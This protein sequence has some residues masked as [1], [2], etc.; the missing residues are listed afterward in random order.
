GILF[1]RQGNPDRAEAE[2]RTALS[3]APNFAPAAVNLADL[4]RGL[5]RDSAGEAV[6]RSALQRSLDD[7]SLLYALGLLIVRN[8]HH[9]EALKLFD[10]AAHG[11]PANAR[12]AYVYAVALND[13]GQ[14]AA[15][16]DVL[17]ANVNTHPFDQD[18]L[19]ALA[20]FLEQQDDFPKAL[21]YAQRFNAL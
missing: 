16:I 8:K 10:A 21:G 6:L 20:T 13:S 18:S 9:A 17:E 11:A 2:L 19:S 5:G 4:Y 12:Y 3:L 7:P 15:A 14:T 1:T